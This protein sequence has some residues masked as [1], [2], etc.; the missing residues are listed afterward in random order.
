MRVFSVAMLLVLLAA[1][2]TTPEEQAEH[3]QMMLERCAELYKEIEEAEDDVSKAY[4]RNNYE[5]TCLPREQQLPDDS[6]PTRN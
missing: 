1:C 4:A 2:G 6:V 3:D 5:N